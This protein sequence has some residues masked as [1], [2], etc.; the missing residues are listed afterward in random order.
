MTNSPPL[1]VLA[2]GLQF[3]E[4][5]IAMADGSVLFVELRRGTLSRVSATGEYG[6]VAMAAV[7]TA[8]SS[9]SSIAACTRSRH[10]V[11]AAPKAPGVDSGVAFHG[12]APLNQVT[13]CH[14]LSSAIRWNVESS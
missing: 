13:R 2:S 8:S 3:P 14:P 6:V 10:S 4:G 12:H 9:A 7:N 11:H 1:T 5:P